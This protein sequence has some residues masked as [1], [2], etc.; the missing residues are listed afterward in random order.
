MAGDAS[1]FEHFLSEV[2]AEIKVVLEDR[3]AA[4][5]LLISE[6]DLGTWRGCTQSSMAA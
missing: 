4:K 2:F 1:N 5:A 3:S 6:Q